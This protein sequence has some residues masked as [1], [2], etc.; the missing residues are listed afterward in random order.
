MFIN[1]IADSRRHNILAQKLL[2]DGHSVIV[3]KNFSELPKR[4]YGDITVL[5][6]PTFSANG[7]FNLPN[8]PT[9]FN[10]ENLFDLL[11]TNSLIISCNLDCSNRKFIDINKYEPFISLNAIPSAEGAISLAMQNTDKTIYKSRILVIGYGRIGKLLATRLKDLGA[12]V[13]VVARNP[14]DRYT[15]TAFGLS[16]CDYGELN[17]LISSFDIIFQTVPSLVLTENRLDLLGDTLIIELSS[18]GAGTD[19]NYAEKIG[20]NL[21]YAPG[22]PEKYSSFSAGLI[23]HDSIISIIREK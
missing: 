21:I 16:A 7:K 22:I 19:M 5:P 13:T 23:L 2:E 15:A 14:K 3:Y 12:D 1:I 20:K 6:I 8:A 18:K 4:V 10:S 11:D 9:D 17:G